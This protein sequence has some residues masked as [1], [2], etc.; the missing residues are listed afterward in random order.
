MEDLIIEDKII[1][2]EKEIYAKEINFSNYEW[3]VKRSIKKTTPGLNY[4]Y[5]DEN[6]VFVDNQGLHLKILNR[7]N[8]WYSS[9]VVLSKSLGYG[10]YSFDIHTNLKD[11]H[12]NLV[13]GLFTYDLTLSKDPNYFH[14]E[15]DFE[16]SQ[17]GS[18]KNNNSQFT[19]QNS[20]FTKPIESFNLYNNDLV[21]SFD[22][23][24]KFINFSVKLNDGT[25]LKNWLY[26]GN[27]IPTPGNERARINLWIY[28]NSKD[29]KETEIII[30]K[31]EFDQN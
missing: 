23:Q 19:I 1:M 28:K 27:K 24:E 17:W 18:D 8:K 4:F 3:L 2:Q 16:I 26:T 13:L 9:E 25:L 22:W 10:K 30:K 7:E 14:R 6:S 11:F 21:V 15:I 5:Y 20:R 31:F 29:L 12:K